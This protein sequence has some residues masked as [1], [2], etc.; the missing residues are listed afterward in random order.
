MK[1]FTIKQLAQIQTVFYVM[2]AVFAIISYLTETE[3][4]IRP[5]LWLA[6]LFVVI[7]VLWRTRLIRCPQCGDRLAASRKIPDTCPNC[8]FDL[9]THPKEGAPNE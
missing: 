2:A 3:G 6:I 9:T 7:S 8:G 4:T 1:K 5:F